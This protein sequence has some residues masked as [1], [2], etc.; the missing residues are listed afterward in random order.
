MSLAGTVLWLGY[1]VLLALPSVVLWNSANL[2]L[3]VILLSVKL[4][5]GMAPRAQRPEG[6]PSLSPQ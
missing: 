1:G 3:L 6:A 2:V 5:Y 4:R